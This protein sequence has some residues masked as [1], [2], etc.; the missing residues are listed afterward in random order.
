MLFSIIALLCSFSLQ[1]VD[2]EQVTSPPIV[3]V[4]NSLTIYVESSSGSAKSGVKAVGGVCGGIACAG[5]TD[6]VYTDS[7][8]K[9]TIYFSDGCRVCKIYLNGKAY[10][11]DYR[12][13]GSYTLRM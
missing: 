8:G 5:Q 1:H 11:G 13:G 7:D 12:D 10:E 3:D 4:R 9:A 6:K 2:V